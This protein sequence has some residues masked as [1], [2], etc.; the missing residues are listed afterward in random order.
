M[1]WPGSIKSTRPIHV[2]FA[3]LPLR[4]FFELALDGGRLGKETQKC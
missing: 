3:A 1:S 4:N 2:Y